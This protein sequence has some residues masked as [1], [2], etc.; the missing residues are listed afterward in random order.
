MARKPKRAQVA[1]E[2]VVI[3]QLEAVEVENTNNMNKIL[4]GGGRTI[5]IVP[6]SRLKVDPWLAR[7]L[8]SG[9]KIIREYQKIS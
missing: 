6:R 5:E 8:P 7:N 4:K 9:V 3:M 2:P 1:A